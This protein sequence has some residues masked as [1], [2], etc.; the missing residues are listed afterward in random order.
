MRR[1]IWHCS[2][3]SGVWCGSEVQNTL[4]CGSEVQN[5]LLCGFEVQN[6]LWC[7]FEAQNT[8]WCGF[9]VQNTL[10]C[11]FEVQNTL[12]CGFEVRHTAESVR[13]ATRVDSCGRREN[14]DKG[15]HKIS[16]DHSTPT[17]PGAT[18][19]QHTVILCRVNAGTASQTMAQH[20]PDIESTKHEKFTQCCFN[21][22]TAS[23]IVDQEWSSTGSIS[24]PQWSDPML[25]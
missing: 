9:E 23:E 6:T 22:G 5:T 12:W 3:D 4:L 1:V 2:P 8:L 10:W 7:G 19:E 20:W 25:L 11:G 17:A 16:M 21:V 24:P 14:P 13:S 18:G 15:D